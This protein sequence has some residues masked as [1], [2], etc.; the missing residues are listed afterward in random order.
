MD[1]SRLK[2]NLKWL[3]PGMRVKRW[4]LLTPI[5][6]LFVIVGVTLLWNMRVVDFL[7]YAAELVL[8]KAGV[9]LS[10]PHVYMPI[11]AVSILFEADE[12]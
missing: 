6:V 9:N 3:Y 2:S 10:L 12:D 11:S 8:T 5:G 7:N 4:L 1:I